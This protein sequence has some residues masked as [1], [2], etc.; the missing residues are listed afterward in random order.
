MWVADLGQAQGIPS[1]PPQQAVGRHAQ[2]RPAAAPVQKRQLA[3]FPLPKPAAGRPRW[4]GRSSCSE[5]ASLLLPDPPITVTAECVAAAASS[6]ACVTSCCPGDTGTYWIYGG[7][8]SIRPP[9]LQTPP[10]DS[11]FTNSASHPLPQ[12]PRP[13]AAPCTWGSCTNGLPSS[14]WIWVIWPSCT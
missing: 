14:Y 4:T 5:G 2:K 10:Q 12:H 8:A 11:P 1:P 7:K 13:R 9:P 3:F 6:W